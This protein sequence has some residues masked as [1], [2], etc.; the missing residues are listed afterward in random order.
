MEKKKTA[1]ATMDMTHRQPPRRT[2]APGYT[3]SL[4][5]EAN[6]KK[7]ASSGTGSTMKHH[8]S[9]SK[10]YPSVQTS[11][12]LLRSEPKAQFPVS[13]RVP[14]KTEISAQKSKGQHGGIRS[15][16][17]SICKNPKSSNHMLR[18]RMDLQFNQMKGLLEQLMVRNRD[19]EEENT[20]LRKELMRLK[21]ELKNCIKWLSGMIGKEETMTGTSRERSTL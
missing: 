3:G 21:E 20:N 13:H 7:P 5:F 12:T 2:G 1:N 10:V 15:D 9:H 8:S 6:N 14:L 4:S 16:S 19:L 18:E 11:A 17:R